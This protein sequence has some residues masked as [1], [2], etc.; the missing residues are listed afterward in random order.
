MHASSTAL[1]GFLFSN[2]H[3][4]PSSTGLR[5]IYKS[6]YWD[7]LK[8]KQAFVQR[9]HSLLGLTT[10]FQLDSF[11]QWDAFYMARIPWTRALSPLKVALIRDLNSFST[12]LDPC[13]SKDLQESGHWESVGVGEKIGEKTVGACEESVWMEDDIEEC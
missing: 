11:F 4:V 1:R 7:F 13:F 8:K 2:T 12:R 5:K 10:R 9:A 6:D 3:P